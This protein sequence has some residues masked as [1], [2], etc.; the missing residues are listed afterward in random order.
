MIGIQYICITLT[1]ITIPKNVEI[2]SSSAFLGCTNLTEI[3]VDSANTHFYSNR[4]NL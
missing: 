2:I 4:N 1:E 3:H